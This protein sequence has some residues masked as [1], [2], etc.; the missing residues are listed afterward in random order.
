MQ[1][2]YWGHSA[3]LLWDAK[4]C[5]ADF[6][7]ARP[8]HFPKFT[9]DVKVALAAGASTAASTAAGAATAAASTAASGASAAASGAPSGSASGI[10]AGSA[11]A[12]PAAAL[13]AALAEHAASSA[14]RRVGRSSSVLCYMSRGAGLR[15]GGMENETEMRRFA[16]ASLLGGLFGAC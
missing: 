9:D 8:K 15:R 2:G 11:R 10:D 13:A 4:L 5:A 7:C 3:G 14:G 6:A 16:T 12:D 1:G